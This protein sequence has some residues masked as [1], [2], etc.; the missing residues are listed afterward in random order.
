MHHLGCG[1]SSKLWDII[2]QTERA[3]GPR[4]AGGEALHVHSCSTHPSHPVILPPRQGPVRRHSALVR[5]RPGESEE[6]NRSPL[7]TPSQI[8][9]VS[10]SN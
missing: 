6:V 4:G 10:T 7:E 2:F 9:S 1:I 8:Q 5:E 3:W